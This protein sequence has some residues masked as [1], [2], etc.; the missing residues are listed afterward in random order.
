M[1]G[2]T[3]L[4]WAIALAPVLVLLLVFEWLDVFH[5]IHVRA[6][7]GLLALGI[8]AG[9]ISYPISGRVL[10]TLPLGFSNYSRFV[11]PWLEEALKAVAVIWLFARNRIGFKL[12]AAISGFAI[13]AGF[14]VVENGI[15]LVNFGHLEFGVWLVR[16]LGT[17]VM[18]G[19]AT[20]LFAVL[21]HQLNEALAKRQAARWRFEP[22]RF[23]PGFLLAVA[24]HTGFN[25]FPDQPLVAMMA[26]LLLVPLA[27][28]LVFRFGEA[29]ARR[30]LAAET[31][32]HRAALA[33]LRSGNFPDT[34]SGRLVEALAERASG[35]APAALIREYLEVHT[36]LV[37]RAEETMAADGK[38]PGEPER[39]L[40]DRYRSLRQ[41]LGRTTLAA[42]APLL[43]FSREELWE[44]RELKLRLKGR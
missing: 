24:V 5:L 18:H 41:Q 40:F 16:G 6:V 19:G 2:A 17:A 7:L 37:L 42:I 4:N 26:A 43:P 25:Q 35:R 32:S 29:E 15:Y 13:G 9:V 21:A 20:A 22:L 14:S 30:W 36:A 34:A 10:D 39:V 8:L 44:M 3:L 31:V 1:D 38:A 28:L 11:A 27:L 23:L 33:E 12:D